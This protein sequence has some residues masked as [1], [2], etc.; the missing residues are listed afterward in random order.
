MTMLITENR[1]QR[2]KRYWSWSCSVFFVCAVSD[3]LRCWNHLRVR[4]QRSRV[5]QVS[6][7]PPLH[8][9]R[10]WHWLH[11]HFFTQRRLHDQRTHRGWVNTH[12]SVCTDVFKRNLMV[13]LVLLHG[14][15]DTRR[16]Q[17]LFLNVQYCGET[18][19]S[20]HENISKV[21]IL[22]SAVYELNMQ[23][24]YIFFFYYLFI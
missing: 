3:R 21:C 23:Y 22:L 11:R 6:G 14:N 16:Q 9:Y 10:K 18:P 5:L 17:V 13:G 1:A 8:D 15:A 24:I 4:R 19:A 2:K 20:R 12:C 7:A